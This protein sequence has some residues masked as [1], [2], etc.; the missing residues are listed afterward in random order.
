MFIALRAFLAQEDG[1]VTVD[2]VVLT[3]SV[4]GLALFAILSAQNGSEALATK[5]H[6]YM[7]TAITVGSG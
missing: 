6:Q 1:A 2:F 3:A 5:M 4:V 7:D